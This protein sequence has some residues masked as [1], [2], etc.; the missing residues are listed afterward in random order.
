MRNWHRLFGLTLIDYFL[1]SPYVVELECDLSVTEQLLDVVIIEQDE[2][3]FTG[4]LPDGLDNLGR[5]NLLTYKSLRQPLD[6]WALDELVGHYVNYRKQR[7]PSPKRL[8]PVEAF[9]LYGVCTREPQK[10]KREA[11][12]TSVQPGVYQVQWGLHPIRIIVTSQVPQTPRNAIWQLFSGRPDNVRYGSEAF[13]WHRADHAT[14]LQQLYTSYAEEGITMAYTWDDFFRDVAREH[15]QE[16]PPEERLAGL[17]PEERLAG[18]GPE[19]RLAGLGPDDVLEYLTSEDMLGHLRAE[20][21]EALL[22][23]LRH[24]Q[25]HQQQN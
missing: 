11:P 9:R 1:D 25:R 15:V 19:E 3:E 24:L 22:D 14:L 23:R 2:G 18:I 17:G 12:V 13:Q 4:E 10:L 16:L 21:I 5:H 7:S 20:Q 8:L 6:A